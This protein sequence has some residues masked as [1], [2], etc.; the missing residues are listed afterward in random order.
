V[1]TAPGPAGHK[2]TAAYP[3]PPPRDHRSLP[4]TVM[5]RAYPPPPLAG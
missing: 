1:D 3:D 4:M 5:G 2:P